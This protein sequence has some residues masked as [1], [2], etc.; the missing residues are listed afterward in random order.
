MKNKSD[1]YNTPA[2]EI[3]KHFHTDM[4][5][6]LH[7]KKAEAYLQKYGKNQLAHKKPDSMLKNFID[8]FK[9]FMIITL[10]IAAGI[11][12]AVSCLEHRM[13][14][15]EPSII[16]AIVIIN[17][18]LGVVQEAKARRSLEALKNLS[19]PLALVYREGELKQIDSSLLV[20][21]DLIVLEAGN[22]VPADARIISVMGLSIEESTLTGETN[23]I[24]KSTSP[25]HQENL[26]VAEQVNMAFSGT[27]VISGHGLAI[28]TATGMNT[29]L[30]HIAGMISSET[31][32]D[33]PL[34]KKLNHTGKLLGTLA[35]IICRVLFVLGIY[36]KQPVFSMFMTSVSLGVAAIPESLPALVTIMLSLGVERMA[37]KRAIIRRLPAVETLGSATVICSDKTGTLTENKMTVV[38]TYTMDT[39]Q[40]LFTYFCLCSHGIDPMEKALWEYADT[41]S[42]NMEAE[43]RKRHLK[44]EL[45]FDSKRKRMTTFHETSKGIMSITK[46]AP[47]IILK[48]CSHILIDGEKKPITHSIRRN[49]EQIF[50]EFARDALRVLALAC[51]EDIGTHLKH[52]KSVYEENMVFVGL[53]GFMD[54]PRKEAEFAV[55]KCRHAGIRPVMITGDHQVTAS[56]IA[57]KLGIC[58]H[59]DQ[60]MSGAQLDQIS[61]AELS[62]VIY[63]YP[64]FARVSPAHKVRLVKAFQNNG[65][66]VAMTGDGV[67]DAPALQ[68]ADIGCA[69]GR[70][71]TDVAKN[72]ADMILMDDNFATIVDAVEEGRGIFQNIKKAVHFLLSCNIGEIMTI[73]VAILLGRAAPLLPVQLL[74]INLVTDSFPAICLGLEPPESDIMNHP[75]VSAAKGLFGGG[76]MF[77]IIVEGMFIGSLALFAYML[78]G[79]AAGSTM[80]F[81]VLSL[82]QLIHSLNMRSS[83][84]SIFKIG[85]F[86][87]KKLLFSVIFCIALQCA[88]ISV[89]TLQMIFHTTS[90]SVSQWIL[91]GILALMPVPLVDLEKRAG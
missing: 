4:E 65:E 32:P 50:Q 13:D 91:V 29:E 3:E 58:R 14:L 2:K 10:L 63:Q 15:I 85:F 22:L 83:T 37:K 88:A 5:N 46:G 25:L 18:I 39:A 1:W 48:S 66:I 75:P 86:T 47:E 61:D 24:D 76:G 42:I 21:G 84:H 54:P 68:K 11:S 41:L 70:S 45:P 62:R 81:A 73:F 6:G 56:A 16:L 67:N 71:G 90:L 77:T 7:Q 78:G 80:C 9:D 23:P 44:D 26:P 36:K 30:G 27:L 17:A 33:T 28:V 34:Q 51:R 52:N 40:R 60:V 57:H 38:K 55:T 31:P 72:A 43:Q 59:H 12:F 87:N 82:S 89:P 19:A 49:I 69:M 79:D 64:V 8:Q 53:A 20:P 35:L 74:F